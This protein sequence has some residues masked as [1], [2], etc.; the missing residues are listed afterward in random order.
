M[1]DLAAPGPTLTGVIL[2]KGQAFS[3]KLSSRRLEDGAM[4][5]SALEDLAPFLP[6]GEMAETIRI[7]PVEG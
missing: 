7:P 1:M 2:D 5:T 6:R 4:V 3:P